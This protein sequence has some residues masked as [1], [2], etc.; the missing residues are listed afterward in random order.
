MNETDASLLG[1][2]VAALIL[3]GSVHLMQRASTAPEKARGPSGL[4]RACVLMG[5]VAGIVL[6]VVGY[7]VNPYF[8]AVMPYCVLV[9]VA[10]L[11]YGFLGLRKPMSS[12]AAVTLEL[13]SSIQVDVGPAPSVW[14]PA[15]RKRLLWWGVPA[16]LLACGLTAQAVHAALNPTKLTARA[17]YPA[18]VRVGDEFSVTVELVNPGERD[19]QIEEICLNPSIEG[20]ADSILEGA[21]M[22][23]IDPIMGHDDV[24]SSACARTE[25]YSVAPHET[26]RV[27]FYFEAVKSG[28]FYTDM[29]F[30]LGE[31]G[32]E[33]ANIAIVLTPCST[34]DQYLEGSCVSYDFAAGKPHTSR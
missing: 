24:A 14:R 16:I 12:P 11:G 17:S 7:L 28:E 8:G 3:F 23:K 25:G 20:Q 9:V 4:A 10:L 22:T 31:R 26:D 32:T 2:A 27:T 13:E 18:R 30:D 33:L 19:I 29:L 34:A 1:I 21:R 15:R 5:G 6:I